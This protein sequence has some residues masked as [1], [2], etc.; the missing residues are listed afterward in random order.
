MPA[1]R[2]S[3]PNP[4]VWNRRLHRWGAAAIALPFVVVIVTGLLLQVKKQ[5]SWVQP[6]EMRTAVRV[7]QVPFDRILEQAR[8]VPEAAVATWDDIDR[9]DVRPAKGML[10]VIA[11]NGWELQLDIASGA[12][13]QVAYRRSDFIETLH[14]M[15]WIHDTANL[16][17]G[18]PMGLIVLGLWGTGLYLWF[19][20]WRGRRRS[21]LAVEGARP[22]RA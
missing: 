15:S 18:V 20:H 4:R 7:P 14:D 3:G 8:S 6:P 12:L 9:V 1:A 21:R 10:K 16:W 2:S 5:V 22:T 17:L 11:R 19:V 13:L